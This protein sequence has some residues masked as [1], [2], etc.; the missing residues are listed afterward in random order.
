[1]STTELD[2]ARVEENA[3]R[4]VGI[5]NDGLLAMALSL[6]H[7]SGLFDTM[8]TLPPSTSNEI[9]AAAGLE[10]RYVRETLG[11]LVVGRIV[12]YDPGGRTYLLP[13][14]Y[15]AVTT[16]AAGVNNIAS[17]A[18]FV[19]MCG[20]VEQEVLQCF[21]E[22]GGV[23]Y[24][25]FPTFHRT[26]AELSKSTFDATLLEVTVPLVP[27]LRERL[28]AG[29]EL[30]DVGCGSG[31]A[32]NLQGRAF[33]A[34]TVT[35]DDFSE[36]AIAAGRATAAEWGLQNVS[37]EVR[38]VS[39]LGLTDACDVVTTFDAIHDQAH[40]AN[41]LAGIAKALRPGGTYLCVE[42]G[43]S[44]NLE[45]NLEHPLGPMLYMVSCMHCMTVSLAL[46]GDGLGAVW[47]EQTA[48]AMLRDAGFTEIRG[49]RVEGDVFNV[50]Y[51]A[52]KG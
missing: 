18:M 40:P 25:K 28:E 41:V 4:L 20:S 34:S 44:S 15:A 33:P 27:G 23:E 17:F 38:D 48:T 36:E 49:E 2:L 45:E 39:D 50:Y 19:G 37:F 26:M 9:A 31:D 35:G 12:T 7:Q 14:E 5:V 52:T 13:P 30:A 1:M 29:I 3:G 24:A 32:I 47:G 22:G 46:D 11:A 21:R 6:G 10:E 8:A 16:R 43:A 42:P 51:I